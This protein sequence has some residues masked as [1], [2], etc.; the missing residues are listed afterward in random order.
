MMTKL[1]QKATFKSVC[2][3]CGKSINDVWICE[4]DSV[5]GTRYAYL[6]THCE[7]L[8][9]ISIDKKT[10]LPIS[11]LDQGINNQLHNDNNLT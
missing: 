11:K 6:C 7:K 10:L 8:L 4:L 3:S 1:L 9:G 2:P 5:I